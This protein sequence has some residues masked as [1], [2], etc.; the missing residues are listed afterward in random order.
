MSLD[1]FSLYVLAENPLYWRDFQL[2]TYN[3]LQS[4][5]S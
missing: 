5:T 1:I 2:V 4:L 3:Y